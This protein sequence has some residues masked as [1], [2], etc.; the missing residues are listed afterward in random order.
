MQPSKQLRGLVESYSDVYGDRDQR[1]ALRAECKSIINCVGVHMVESGFTEQDVKEFLETASIGKILQKFEES[2]E[3]EKVVSHLNDE[4]LFETNRVNIPGACAAR[5]NE[6]ILG[7]IIREAYTVNVADKKGNTKAYQNYKA[8]MKNKLTGKPLYKAGP[9]VEEAK[10]GGDNDPCWDTHKQVGMKKKGGKMVPNCVPKEEAEQVDEADSLAA[11]AAR[12]EKRLAA[13][14]KREGTTGAGHDFGHDYGLTSAE[15][16]K[17]QDKEFDAFIGRGKK[18]KKEAFSFDEDDLKELDVFGEAIDVL[19]DEELVDMMEELILEL[20]E[21]DQDLI[22]ICEHLEE[23]DLLSEASDSYYDSAV[24]S[25][26]DAARKNRMARLKKAAGAAAKKVGSMAKAGAAKAGSAA[27]AGAKAAAKGAVRGAGYASGLA[28]RA[29]SSA[30]S[31]FKKGRE[32]GLK[33]SGGSSSS[34][35]DGTGG[36]LD[37][38]LSSIRSEKPAK[39]KP[40]LLRRAAGAVGRGLKKA[41]GKAARGVSNAADRAA[42]K[43]GEAYKPIDKKKE[44][45]MYRRAGNLSRDALS[46]GMSTKAGSKAQ[47][48]SSNIV[49]AIARQKEKER[50]AK[51]GDEKA[52]SNYGESVDKITFFLVSEGLAD[53]FEGAERMIEGLSEEFINEILDLA[54]IEEKMVQGII[55]MGEAADADEA[56]YILSE[57]DEETLDALAEDVQESAEDRLRDQRME[58]GGVDGNTRYDR[59]PKAPNTKKFGTGK[60]AMQKELEKKHGKGKSAMD[61]VKAE[62][63]AKYGRGSVK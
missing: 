48:K 23:A 18:T 14:R 43:M 32:R 46:K 8:G 52:R 63:R 56:R 30:K 16:K 22:E 19:S 33:S 27:K 7:R 44:T 12:R 13:Q 17:R 15:R 54:L 51:M 59:A 26:K 25:S 40:S 29:S 47:D 42:K 11:M 36:K 38:V 2:Q 3:N 55:E 50:F 4:G 10:N 5:I 6:S 24:K 1:N 57:L 20:A 61:I 49:S 31:E 37:S 62:I 34:S 41:V 60:T 28:Q 21:D 39:K 35:D 9:G 58:R 53:T 45:A